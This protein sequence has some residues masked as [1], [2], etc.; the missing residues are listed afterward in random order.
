MKSLLY[1]VYDSEEKYPKI[2]DYGVRIEECEFIP[3]ILPHVIRYAQEHGDVRRRDS[4]TSFL[5]QF[6]A[7]SSKPE[8]AKEVYFDITLS[9]ARFAFE[10]L[11]KSSRK[12]DKL[13]VPQ[14]KGCI[15]AENAYMQGMHNSEYG[16]IR[17]VYEGMAIRVQV[18]GT[19]GVTGRS[20]EVDTD[21][22]KMVAV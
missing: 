3:R 10:A 22:Q 21:L 5:R 6:K 11:R 4:V 8:T 19:E 1:E 13:I 15:D 18:G 16:H 14:L 12:V 7:D 2:V 17:A 20:E 9:E